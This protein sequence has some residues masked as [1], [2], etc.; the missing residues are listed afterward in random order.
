LIPKPAKKTSSK[1]PLEINKERGK[2]RVEGLLEINVTSAK[3]TL[4]LLE[5]GS[6]LRVV[7]S[8]A[9]NDQS[10]RSQRDNNNYSR[11]RQLDE[12]QVPLGGLGRLGAPQPSRK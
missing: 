3:E 2:F 6:S 5:K 10:S 9:I 1:T 8:T 7:S 4:E 11:A 12:E